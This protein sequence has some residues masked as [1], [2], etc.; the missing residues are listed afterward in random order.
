MNLTW[1]KCFRI[2]VSVFLLFLGIYYWKAAAGLLAVLLRAV[3]PFLIGLAIAFILNILMS[4]YE[5]HYFKKRSHKPWVWK[6]R[7]PVCLLG[8]LLTLA[9]LLALLIALVVPELV[10]CI[11]LFLAAVP[12]AHISALPASNRLVVSTPTGPRKL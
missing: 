7:R 2:G 5:R 12:P 11:R 6:S 3:M 8:A 4:F 1:K 9:G 10:S